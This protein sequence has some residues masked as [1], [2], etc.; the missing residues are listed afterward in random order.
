MKRSD[1]LIALITAVLC[2]SLVVS[3]AHAQGP[4]PIREESPGLLAQAPTSPALARLT[5]FGEFPGAH[6]VAAEVRREASDIL[7]RFDFK[8]DNHNDTEHVVISALTGQVIRVEYSVE[9]DDED[10]FAIAGPPEL[11]SLVQS[12]YLDART[13]VDATVEHGHVVKCMLRVEGSTEIYVFDVRVGD[14]DVPEQ[15]LVDANT[16]TLLSRMPST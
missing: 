12:S 14:E 3:V 15:V 13:K 6:M 4:V 7:Y 5:A 10:H 8:F 16:C 11:L 2:V 1:K 9:R